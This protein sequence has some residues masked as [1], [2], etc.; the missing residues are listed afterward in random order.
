M[1]T[2]PPQPTL[3]S[4]QKNKK[5]FLPLNT[6][7]KSTAGYFLI[8]LILEIEITRYEGSVS[9]VFSFIIFFLVLN[10]EDF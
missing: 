10:L 5:K 8:P 2:L 1:L 3:L 7:G 9:S 6:M 4:F